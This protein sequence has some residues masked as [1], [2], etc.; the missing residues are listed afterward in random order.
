MTYK[1]DPRR[2]DEIE[3]HV[4]YEVILAHYDPETN[5]LVYPLDIRKLMEMRGITV[6]PFGDLDPRQRNAI[7]R[8]AA[9]ADALT[10]SQGSGWHTFYRDGVKSVGRRRYTLAHEL[11]H[12][13]LGNFGETTGERF[14]QEES[15][16]DWFAEYLLAP[17]PIVIERLALKER[18]AEFGELDSASLEKEIQ[19]DFAVSG[20]CAKVVLAHSISRLACGS[21][22]KPYEIDLLDCYLKSKDAVEAKK[23]AARA[24][25]LG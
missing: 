3:R 24:S 7:R 25:R 14:E 6:T 23:G 21:K 2:Y 20:E 9:G 12:I 1:L 5:P 11:G 13:E 17:K 10:L 22:P 4:A 15:E 18:L 8:E 16:V 19:Q